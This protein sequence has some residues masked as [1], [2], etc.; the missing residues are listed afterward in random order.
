M[1]RP[2]QLRQVGRLPKIRGFKPMGIP[3]PDM[4]VLSLQ[5]D[6]LE[7]LR[8]ADREGLYQ[9][10]AAARMG[11]SRVTFG[12]ILQKARAKVAEALLDGKALVIGEGPVRFGPKADGSCPVHGGPRRRGRACRCGPSDEDKDSGGDP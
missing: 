7:A 6:E 4:E 12:R 5:V 3:M 8:L 2:L 11:V 1:P 10:E 9:E